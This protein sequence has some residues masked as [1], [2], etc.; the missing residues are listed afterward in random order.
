M[1]LYS[2][3]R[4]VHRWIYFGGL[5][6]LAIGLPSSVFLMSI[7]QIIL[8]LNWLAEAQFREKFRRFFDNRA[9][10]IFTSIYL[11]H[12]LAL[13][14]S[15]NW[16]YGVSTL[17][18]RLPIFLL[19]LIV[20][21]SEPLPK[22]S[23]KW[24]P[25]A[26]A[27][28]ITVVSL[29]S[30]R[31]YLSGDFNDYRELSPFVSHI[32][33]S[34]MVVL[35]VFLMLYSAK[36]TFAHHK[37]MSLLCYGLAAWHTAYLLMLY[38]LSGLLVFAAVVAV[39]TATSILSLPRKW[40]LAFFSAGLVLFVFG[41]VFLLSLWGNVTKIRDKDI[42]HLEQYSTLGTP[43]TH[44]PG[45]SFREN[46]YL[47]Y[48]YIAEEELREKW[49]RSSELDYD[50]YNRRGEPVKHVLFR[51][52]ASM[53]LRKDASGFAQLSER[54]I[55][56]VEEGITNIRYTQWPWIVTRVHQTLWELHQ[57][58]I[59]RNPSGH[60]FAMRLEFWQAALKAI[61][62]K[63][64]LGWGTG[65]IR[66]ASFYGLE[67]INS[68]LI[69]ERWMKPHNQYLSFAILFGIPGMLWIIFA[70]VYPPLKNHC[71]RNSPCVA[72]FVILA[73]SML[74]E[75]TIDTQAGLSFFVFFY[76]YFVFLREDINYDE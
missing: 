76:N 34:L 70:M 15:S 71:H 4:T 26:F 12:V 54:D 2:K 53:G 64:F 19:T 48:I 11:V 41:I 24:L 23:K 22:Q 27:G 14:Y 58:R 25:L 62:K 8:F 65:D 63:P 3:R 1:H 49:N 6:L 18:T 40:R 36:R 5:V 66:E 52:M 44:N 42:T 67:K 10:L 55:E 20:V 29:F 72:F 31:I 46:G 75:D 32:R 9:A 73:I 60:S 17:R 51:Y 56:A 38:S 74:N 39:L 50:G 59:A 35:S 45:A 28:A 13:F 30:I 7:S 37:S 47:V 33:L 16:D 21:S 68:S 43:Y 61:E 69:F 57:Y